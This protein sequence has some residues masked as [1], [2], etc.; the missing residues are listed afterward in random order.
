MCFI[1]LLE[2]VQVK[3]NHEHVPGSAYDVCLLIG[4]TLQSTVKICEYP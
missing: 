3:G 1:R 2:V 4:Q